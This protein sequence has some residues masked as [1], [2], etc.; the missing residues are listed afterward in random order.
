MLMF[1]FPEMNVMVTGR[2]LSVRFARR[3]QCSFGIA[4]AFPGGTCRDASAIR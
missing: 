4:Q 1:G 2:L 3:S